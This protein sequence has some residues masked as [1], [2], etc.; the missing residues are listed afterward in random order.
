[1]VDDISHEG[2][3][4]LLHDE[5][6]SGSAGVETAQ[7]VALEDRIERSARPAVPD[8]RAWYPGTSGD[9]DIPVPNGLLVV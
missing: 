8:L 2:L 7:V 9:T 6:V 1:V 4:A 3:R 5:G